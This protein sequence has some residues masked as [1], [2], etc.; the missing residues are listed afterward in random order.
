MIFLTLKDVKGAC[1]EEAYA[2]LRKRVIRLYARC[3]AVVDSLAG[4]VRNSFLRVLNGDV[5]V[6]L[7]RDSLSDLI[8]ILAVQY[9]EPVIV[10]L[11]EYDSPVIEAFRYGYLDEMMEFLRAW[12]GAALKHENGPALFRAVVTGILRIAKESIF[13]GL[14]NLDVAT[15]LK[16]SPFEDKFGFTEPE[17]EQ[18]LRDYDCADRM[19]EVRDWYNGYKFGNTVIYNP[20]SV[21]NY[22]RDIPNLAGPKWLNTASNDLVHAELEA[23]G[24]AIRRDLEK[25]LAGAELRYPIREDTVFAD[26]GNSPETI[27][28]FLYFAGYLRAEDPR[29]DKMNPLLQMY[30]L[31]IPNK[32]VTLA[33]QQF[34]S[35]LFAERA[36]WD[37]PRLR[38]FLS[39]LLEDDAV[40]FESLLQELVERLLSYYDVGRCPEAVYHAFILGLLANLRSIYDI[41]S[42][43]ESGYGRSDILMVRSLYPP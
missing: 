27:W 12:L 20:W 34:V 15:T 23:G 19:P 13:S 2:A 8:D 10:L 25:L 41:R 38:E 5:D 43:P 26:V 32:E 7:M 30:R 14:N 3:A 21:L 33:Y 24:E 29:L 37:D 42:N 17:V 39:A 31:C 4:E 16:I 1:W 11:D 6:S 40:R 35:R 22:V 9:D 28:S 18:L 36:Q